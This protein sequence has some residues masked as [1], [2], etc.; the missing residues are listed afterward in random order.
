MDPISRLTEY[1]REFPGIGP[2]QARRFVY[3][4]LTRNT[5]ALEE[6]SRLILEIKKQVH[7]CNRCF[8]FFNT[9]SNASLCPICTDRN[10]DQSVLLV[11]SKDADF[12][13]IEKTHVHQGLYFILG[14][15]VPILEKNPE[16]RVRSRELIARLMSSFET[17]ATPIKELVLSFSA[18]PDGEHT[19]DF[20]RSIT[21][22]IALEKGITVTILGRGLSTGSELEYADGETIRSAFMNRA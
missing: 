16:N 10:R 12:E 5:A 19:T 7:V 17:G 20:I 21:K 3:Y 6:L 18:T 13:A 1:F 14:G 2:R 4:L 8:R 9:Q 11:V 22:E 15:V